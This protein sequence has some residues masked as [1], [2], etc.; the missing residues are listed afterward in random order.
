MERTKTESGKD[1]RRLGLYFL[2]NDHYWCLSH[3]SLSLF[4]CFCTW[5]LSLLPKK[6]KNHEDTEK[7]I[8]VYHKMLKKK[9]CFAF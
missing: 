9:P 6:P 7:N 4:L 1:L 5:F 2:K 8:K 3:L